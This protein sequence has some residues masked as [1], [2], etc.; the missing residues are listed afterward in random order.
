MAIGKTNNT[1]D[2]NIK[3][4]TNFGLFAEKKKKASPTIPYSFIKAPSAIINAAQKSCSRLIKL[5]LKMISAAIMGLLCTLADAV[6]NSWAHN[7]ST[8]TY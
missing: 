3:L 6:I 7:K 5:K 1:T 2:Q 8:I 4:N